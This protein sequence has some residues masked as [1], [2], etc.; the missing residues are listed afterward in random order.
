MSVEIIVH[1]DAESLAAAVA[2][3][4][5]TS[6]IDAQ[7][8]RGRAAVVLTGGGMGGRSQQAV[9]ASPAA[10]AV[11]WENVDFYWGDERF[12]PKGHPDRNET[13]AREKLLTPLS[14]AEARIHA[15]PASDGKWGD[16]AVAAAA[17]HALELA[18][19]AG[20]DS[21]P[22]GKGTGTGARAAGKR[23]P[24]GPPRSGSARDQADAGF[25]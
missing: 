18:E 22:A 11:D 21:S 2:A 12:L 9:V 19:L 6:I 23:G 13:Q 20:K 1:P 5:I 10:R 16:D 3:R 14:I 17:G 15:M 24:H 25:D 7:A 4:L 8:A